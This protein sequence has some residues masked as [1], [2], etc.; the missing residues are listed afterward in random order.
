MPVKKFPP[1]ADPPRAEKVKKSLLASPRRSGPKAEGLG[2]GVYDLTG[3]KVKEITLSPVISGAKI[4]KAL[5]SQAVRVYLANQRKGTA[6]T[7]TRGEVRGSTRKIQRQKHTGHA[8]H[9]GIRAPIFVGGGIA[10]GP[11]P[12]SFS[13]S[14]PKKMKKSALLSALAFKLKEKA[15]RVVRNLEE[16]TPKTKKVNE[17]FQKLTPK[18]SVLLIITGYPQGLIRA[19]R[20]IKLVEIEKVENIN[21]YQVLKNKEL[22]FTEDA[23]KVLEKIYEKK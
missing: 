12:H 21:T 18:K 20:N 11:R 16:I 4:N 19:A 13:L 10:F 23:V 17:L 14:L 22:I 5:L 2:V 1:K 8:R 3:K 9:G 15:I 7:K 6:S